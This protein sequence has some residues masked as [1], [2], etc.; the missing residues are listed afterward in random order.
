MGKVHISL[1]ILNILVLIVVQ[2]YTVI[3]FSTIAKG[4]NS[5][6]ALQV[7]VIQKPLMMPLIMGMMKAITK[8]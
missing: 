4:L 7:E 5:I 6:V 8:V 2:G 1:P 3:T